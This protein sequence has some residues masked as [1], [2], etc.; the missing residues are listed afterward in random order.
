M[1]ME[2]IG[3]SLSTDQGVSNEDDKFAVAVY[4]EL[5]IDGTFTS[6]I[7]QNCSLFYREWW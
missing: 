3:D 2:A 4:D 1:F 5:G 7:Q 6:G